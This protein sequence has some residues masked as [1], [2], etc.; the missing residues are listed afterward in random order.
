MRSVPA[1]LLCVVVVGCSPSSSN[2]ASTTTATPVPTTAATTTTTLSP[3]DSRVAFVSCLTDVGVEVPTGAFD[4]DGSPRLGVIAE[5]LDTTEPL[6]QAAVAECAPL[7]SV[8]QAVDLAADPEVR[9]LVIEQLAAFT[10]CMR[11]EGIDE[12]PDP[13]G[14]ALAEGPYAFEDVPFSVPGFDEALATCQD[15]VGSFGMGGG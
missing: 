2:G 13:A 10:Q 12:F 3:A 8:T 9:N 11:D 14:E 1:L 15:V 4:A 6:V 7:L 5:S